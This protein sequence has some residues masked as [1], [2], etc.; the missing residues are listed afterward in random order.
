MRRVWTSCLA[1]TL[2]LAGGWDVEAELFRMEDLGRANGEPVAATGTRA[3]NPTPPLSREEVNAALPFDAELVEEV[4]SRLGEWPEDSKL[5]VRRIPS[6]SPDERDALR[7]KY[8]LPR[9]SA[10][11][12]EQTAFNRAI[13]GAR[14][15]KLELVLDYLQHGGKVDH[16]A[17]HG[18]YRLPEETLLSAAVHGN[19]IEIV[20]LLLARGA[21]VN[22][23]SYLEVRPVEIAANDER[24]PIIK[25]LLNRGASLKRSQ[26]GKTPLWNAAMSGEVGAIKLLLAQGA[27]PNELGTYDEPPLSRAAGNGYTEAV[28]A[29]LVGGA[30]VNAT[31]KQG[32]TPLLSAVLEN[33]LEIVRLLVEHGADVNQADDEGTA[34]LDRARRGYRN[35]IV[36]YLTS[37]GALSA[38]DRLRRAWAATRPPSSASVPWPWPRSSRSPCAEGMPSE[39]L[40]K[41]WDDPEYQSFLRRLRSWVPPLAPEEASQSSEELLTASS[42]AMGEALEGSLPSILNA[43]GDLSKVQLDR[44]ALEKGVPRMLANSGYLLSQKDRLTHLKADQ[45]VT[46]EMMLQ[47]GLAIKYHNE[48][49]ALGYER[50]WEL[51]DLTLTSSDLFGALI[52]C[53]S[54]TADERMTAE[55][56]NLLIGVTE[57]PVKN[58]AVVPPMARDF[59][60]LRAQLGPWLERSG[61]DARAYSA[62]RGR[63]PGHLPTAKA[64]TFLKAT[65]EGKRSYLA[66]YLRPEEYRDKPFSCTPFEQSLAGHP[67]QDMSLSQLSCS[68]E[69]A[70]I[71]LLA[72]LAKK[73][74]RTGAPLD[75]KRRYEFLFLLSFLARHYG[76]VMERH[77]PGA[78]AQ[79]IQWASGF[80]RSIDLI[81]RPDAELSALEILTKEMAMKQFRDPHRARELYAEL[82]ELFSY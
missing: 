51:Y 64:E 21:D 7:E 46:V 78:R 81:D 74:G 66:L 58:R 14:Y 70:A 49:Q 56:L 39:S 42:S 45:I 26:T 3:T 44:P 6:S 18:E 19:Q 72:D 55:T 16:R 37:H 10:M 47:I 69:E 36:N 60:R 8:G 54:L 48:R 73:A 65:E 41:L 27:D 2:L 29:L 9:R 25:E 43:Q 61:V 22:L 30:R 17:D 59:A 67:A 12:R 57:P 77:A 76:D 38:G 35:E 62:L 32:N 50:A 53:S 23:S 20:R 80:V 13:E 33:S 52:P 71:G 28:R 63:L 68:A 34:P 4:M 79:F 1:F 82:R 11:T 5:V 24:L 15:G 40:A 75:E 31:D